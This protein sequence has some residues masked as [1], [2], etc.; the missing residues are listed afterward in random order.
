VLAI[1]VAGAAFRR[2]EVERPNCCTGDHERHI[3]IGTSLLVWRRRRETLANARREG[4]LF[5]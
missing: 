4:R 3:E 1:A 5:L 2:R